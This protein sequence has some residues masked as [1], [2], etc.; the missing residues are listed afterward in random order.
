MNPNV[1]NE[2]LQLLADGKIT[3]AEAIELLDK[4]SGASSPTSEAVDSL[5]AQEAMSIQA[6]PAI[7]V[8]D[9]KS[10]GQEA[11]SFKGITITEDDVISP[12]KNGGR[13]RWLKIRVMD[14]ATG[15][16]KVAVT[17]P[18]SLVNFGLGV[19][20]RFGADFDESE[21]VEEIWRLLKEG[22]RGVIVDVQDDE[23]SEHVQIYLD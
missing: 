23:D 21:N 14:K 17:L 20:K 1:R 3:A 12:A 19:A 5:K 2:I 8:A 13:P 9:W 16:N 22:E 11:E 18:L 6:E 15:R 10:A 4:Q 7:D